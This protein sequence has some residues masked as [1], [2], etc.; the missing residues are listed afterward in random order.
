MSSNEN[1]DDYNL[2]DEKDFQRSRMQ[3]QQNIQ[4]M[5]KRKLKNINKKYLHYPE[6]MKR[7][8]QIK[9]VFLNIDKD[10]S[11]MIYIIN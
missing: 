1:I 8:M 2:E 9:N 3:T 7:N 10:G 6:E 11:G 4:W 5:K